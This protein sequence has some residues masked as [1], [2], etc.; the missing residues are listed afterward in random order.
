MRARLRAEGGFAL[1]SAVMLLFILL[2]LGAGLVYYSNGQQHA[3]TGEQTREM[4][5]ELAEAALN[6]QVGQLSRKWPAN[7][8]EALPER[9]TAA[10]STAT[11]G[12]PEPAIIKG[13]FSAYPAGTCAAGATEPWGSPVTNSWTTYVREDA[14]GSQIFNSATAEGLPRWDAEGRGKLWVR[15]VGVVACHVVSLVTLVSRQLVSI[16]FPKD[17]AEGNWFRITNKGKKVI[18]NRAGEP[19]ASQPGEVVMRCTGRAEGTC[20]E[21][22]PEKEQISPAPVKGTPAPE[23]LLNESQLESLKALAQSNGTFYSGAAGN[24]PS[25]S[26]PSVNGFP[27]YI[28]G[29]GELKF[30]TGVGNSAASPGLLI[31][32]DGTLELKGN[33]EYFG[34]IYAHNAQKSSGAIVTLGGTATVWGAIDVDGNGGIEF[35]SS[36]ANLIYEPKAIG[37]IVGSAGAT[38]TRNTFRVLPIGQ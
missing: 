32:A 1:I 20:E 36:K 29:C 12:C 19:P 15:A 33:A 21:W 27:T 4:A 26:L 22:A 30:T 5:F 38:P 23:Q 37:S 7:A 11:N 3:A 8:T 18:V 17:A 31:L 10:T 6:A 24:C 16:P 2:G 25:G 34:V 35:G 28:E 14:E 13:A 9:C